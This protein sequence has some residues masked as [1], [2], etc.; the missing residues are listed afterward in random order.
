M[1][2]SIR[3]KNTKLK[4]ETL[5]IVDEDSGI[6]IASP[7]MDTIL[8]CLRR[9]NLTLDTDLYELTMS[10]GYRM[11]GRGGRTACFDLYY[12]QNP[13]DGGFCVFAG[14]ESAISYINNLAVYPDDIEYLSRTGIFSTEAL[15]AIGAGI[16]FTG[17]VWAVPEGTIV[18]PNEPLIRVVGP[19]SEAQVEKPLCLLW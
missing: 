18:F 4:L 12:R 9:D 15:E 14:L 11:L 8:N 10:A 17:D 2:L 19:I 6:V 7:E 3:D 5:E 1:K 13:D 16:N